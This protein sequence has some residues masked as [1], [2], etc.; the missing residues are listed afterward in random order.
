[1]DCVWLLAAGR[2]LDSLS[3]EPRVLCQP[4]PRVKLK[5][6]PEHIKNPVII[7]QKIQIDKKLF[8][9]ASTQRMLPVSEMAR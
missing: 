8:V 2:L 7:V 9:L 6:V 4:N 1:M 5:M 3:V